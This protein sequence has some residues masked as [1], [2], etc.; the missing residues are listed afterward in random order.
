MTNKRYYWFKMKE[1]FFNSDGI[2]YLEDIENGYTYIVFF[3]K[4]CLDSLN[5]DG[6][7]IRQLKGKLIPHDEKSL[8]RIVNMDIDINEA[9]NALLEA[10][11]I[12]ILEDGTI[13]II[14]LA[15]MT[16]S[17]TKWAEKK[18]LQRQKDKT[19]TLSLNCPI[20][21]ETDKEKEK[22]KDKEKEFFLLSSS[23]DFKADYRD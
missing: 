21:I 19:G 15:D 16:G 14:G 5:A 13:Y 3:Q 17:E 8:K 22:E 1:D 20:D 6:K 11:L 10:G 18:R 9:M 2:R 23:F 4:L 7:L 12:D